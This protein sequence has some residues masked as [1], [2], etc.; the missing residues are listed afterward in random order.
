MIGASTLTR[1]DQIVRPLGILAIGSLGTRHVVVPQHR[2]G[3]VDQA[4]LDGARLSC[5]GALIHSLTP[6]DLADGL[7]RWW[8]G[9]FT[10][11]VFQAQTVGDLALIDIIGDSVAGVFVEALDVRREDQDPFLSALGRARPMTVVAAFDCDRLKAVGAAI[12]E[13][14]NSNVIGVWTLGSVVIIVP[15]EPPS[16]ESL[17]SGGGNVAAWVQ[18]W[19]IGLRSSRLSVAESPPAGSLR[20]LRRTI[21]LGRWGPMR[22]VLNAAWRH[23]GLGQAIWYWV[24]ARLQRQRC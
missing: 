22:R 12:L 14:F 16:I 5:P 6:L 7:P 13:P 15:S 24:N 17:W 19:E 23:G 1:L 20:R 21:W 4:W 2:T 10:V 18:A 9:E 8:P 3:D 11:L